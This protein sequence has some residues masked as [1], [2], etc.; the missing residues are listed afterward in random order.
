MT[1][2]A[3]IALTAITAS[4]ALVQQPTE[5]RVGATSL[6][7]QQR[8]DTIVRTVGR[9]RYPGVATPVPEIAIGGVSATADEYIFTS[10]AE[11]RP[12]VNGAIVV[13]DRGLSSSV[14]VRMY[15]STGRYVRTLGRRGEGPGEYT[16][17]NGIAQL[18]DGRVLVRDGQG[19]RLAAYDLATGEGRQLFVGNTGVSSS[20]SDM[21]FVSPDG[22]ILMRTPLVSPGTPR[23]PLVSPGTPFGIGWGVLRLR[24]NGSVIDTLRAPELPNPGPPPLSARGSG[25]G[26]VSSTARVPFTSTAAAVLSP[27]GYFATWITGRYAIDLRVPPGQSQAAGEPPRSWRDGD[28]VTSIRRTVAPVAVNGAER[29]ER[30]S[31]IEEQMRR[32]QPG[33][34]WNGPEIPRVKPPINSVRVGLDGRLWVQLSTVSEKIDP[35]SQPVPPPGGVG[36]GGGGGGGGGAGAAV[37]TSFAPG[38]PITWR[39]P[40]LY[41]VLEPNGTYIGQ[42]SVPF[43]TSLSAMRGDFAWGTTRDADGVQTVH[44]FR[45]VWR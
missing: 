33:W 31:R 32:A 44:R 37:A 23:T 29:A 24:T 13:V 10:V 3:R 8:S 35:A 15:D 39:E 12:L 38:T 5:G 25:S 11:V 36:G 7:K 16:N 20:G 14:S 43:N 21:L 40:S 42:V 22:T 26:S 41:D 34:Q 9:P 4:L 28:P 19:S 2:T 18:P 45:I 27:L 17:P 6:S 1:Q 30:R